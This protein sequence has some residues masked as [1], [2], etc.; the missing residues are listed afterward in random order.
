MKCK[1]LYI[2]R[3][4]EQ[5]FLSAAFVLLLFIGNGYVSG[6]QIPDTT[7]SCSYAFRWDPASSAF[8]QHIIREITKDKLKGLSNTHILMNVDVA[9]A[10]E[11]NDEG[12]SQLK[13]WVQDIR[14]SGD[15]VFQDFRIDTVLFPQEIHIECFDQKNNENFILQYDSLKLQYTPITISH[16]SLDAVQI[17]C[18][19]NLVYS[20]DA[21][22][23][24]DRYLLQIKAYMGVN[25]LVD[26]LL[27]HQGDGRPN[28]VG[29][30]P[31]FLARLSLLGQLIEQ[32]HNTVLWTNLHQ[33]PQ[34]L[35]SKIASLQ[36]QYYQKVVLAES[37]A[38]DHSVSWNTQEFAERYASSILFLENNL[39]EFIELVNP[40]YNPVLYRL[41]DSI[42]PFPCG[43]E[44][45]DIIG[46][47]FDFQQTEIV[48][49]LMEEQLAKKYTSSAKENLRNADYSA[50][51]GCVT[52][53][54]RLHQPKGSTELSRLKAKLHYEIYFSYLSVAEQSIKIG[55]TAFATEFIGKARNYQLCH[56][57][58]I[59]NQ[60]Y[61][62]VI[63]EKLIDAL[64]QQAA[65]FYKEKQ[66][67]ESLEALLTA[68]DIA[69]KATIPLESLLYEDLQKTCLKIYD[70]RI[71]D[72]M[73]LMNE[74]NVI[75]ARDKFE[76]A[77]AFREKYTALV[78][79]GIEEQLLRDALLQYRLS[80]LLSNISVNSG[81]FISQQ[82]YDSLQQISSLALHDSLIIQQ[83]QSI[84]ETT[85]LGDFDSAFRSLYRGNTK[86]AARV[87]EQ[88]YPQLEFFH[89]QHDSLLVH[90][91][92][93]LRHQ[94]MLA[95]K[96]EAHNKWAQLRLKINADL[97]QNNFMG[98]DRLFK[99]SET[100][101]HPDSLE[102]NADMLIVDSL[103]S[104]YQ[105]II[106]Y[107]SLLKSAEM[108]VEIHEF[109]LALHLFLLSYEKIPEHKI[110]D[111]GIA[112]KNIASFL[113][114]RSDTAF[115]FYSLRYFV[116]E[117]AWENAW[118]SL[119]VLRE[120]NVA[121][122]RT[123]DFQAK[124]ANAM[125]QKDIYRHKNATPEKIAAQ[126]TKGL[127]WFSYFEKSY[128]HHWK[129]HQ[130]IF[131]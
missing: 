17:S 107:T 97:Q 53:A 23:D 28:G 114:E 120:Q 110:A 45:Y 118:T 7:Y 66:Y 82:I 11:S 105:P 127:D 128:I 117:R 90:F 30:L 78:R 123:K 22:D 101:P 46:E 37:L 4:R 60:A 88:I 96:T 57:K 113:K 84:A 69:A 29:G 94:L 68:K 103:K 85:I 74:N 79:R 24:F 10:K 15:N 55:N 121:C 14:F 92:D 13:F 100:Y 81:Q 62:D 20:P 106:E 91:S 43:M 16:T 40:F 1:L 44:T 131:N 35:K 70:Q 61:A 119:D 95:K 34:N 9:C 31:E 18:A 8:Q 99:E 49:V 111:I 54:E 19:C 42:P 5:V 52:K 122:S 109:Q 47:V 83:A 27:L 126:Y 26:D 130:P 59:I 76:A 80:Q 116:Q 38:K 6:Q 129:K 51:L 12:I 33:D 71:V 58:S 89:L 50:A 39:Y 104:V 63:A 93:S 87:W 56:S 102:V 36:A 72:A 64:K 77:V 125:V 115:S 41:M 124:I 98:L 3:N 108:A 73:H 25:A 65:A 32:V 21:A 86:D 67:L 75:A 2:L 112:R 48:K